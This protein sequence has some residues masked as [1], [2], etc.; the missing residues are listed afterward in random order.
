VRADVDLVAGVGMAPASRA[1]PELARALEHQG[2][3]AAFGKRHCA[4][5]AG[6]PAAYNNGVVHYATDIRRWRKTP[7]GIAVPQSPR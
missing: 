5:K 1:S 2:P 7:R 6:E 3:Q 4:R